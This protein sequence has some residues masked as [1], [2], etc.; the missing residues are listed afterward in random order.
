LAEK[1][2]QLS[3]EEQQQL[4]EKYDPEAATRKLKGPLGWI[5]F[6]GC[7]PFRSFSYMLLFFKRFQNKF[8]C[9]FI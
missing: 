1:F 4:M 2:E 6:L 7:F 3:V 5:V 9:P 8:Y